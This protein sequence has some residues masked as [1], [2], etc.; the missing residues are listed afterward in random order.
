[1]DFDCLDLVGRGVHLCYDDV[2]AVLVLLSQ[3]VPDG[4]QLF[5]VS[6]PGCI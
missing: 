2:G 6:T 5:A 1:M 4:S 3:L